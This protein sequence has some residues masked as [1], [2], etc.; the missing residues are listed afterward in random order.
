MRGIKEWFRKRCGL[1]CKV[2]AHN[3]DTASNLDQKRDD[4]LKEEDD[5]E[6]DEYI[7]EEVMRPLEHRSSKQSNCRYEET[8]RK[9][10]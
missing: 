5:K 9:D 10:A 7:N 4:L 6:Q 3:F 1:L 8:P 2:H